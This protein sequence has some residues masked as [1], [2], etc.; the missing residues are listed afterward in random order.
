MHSIGI[1]AVLSP[2]FDG[3][4][5]AT[6]ATILDLTNASEKEQ[7]V[8]KT[9]NAKAVN[10][11]ILAFETAE[12][13][14]KIIEEQAHDTDW[15]GGKFTRLW[16]RIQLDEKPDDDMAEFEL[17][18]ELRKITLSRKKDPKDLL[19]KILAVEIKFGIT[20]SDKK[21]MAVVL[22]AG[23]RDYAQVMTVQKT[24]TKHVKKRDLTL[25]EMVMAV[26]KQ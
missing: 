1:K 24:I 6:E 11:C 20:C 25:R 17:D 8:A 23:K 21:K 22:C 19:A 10:G 5:P 26:Y 9:T 14:N 13:M 4:L 16:E 15:P 2:W 3:T 7:S 18:E 12:M